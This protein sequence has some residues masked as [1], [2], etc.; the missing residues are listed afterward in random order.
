MYYFKNRQADDTLKQCL[1]GCR[2]TTE[3]NPVCGSDN[4][5]YSNPGRLECAKSC[6]VG[7]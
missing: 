6:G 5:T 3:F 2:V 1:T 4:I 7:K